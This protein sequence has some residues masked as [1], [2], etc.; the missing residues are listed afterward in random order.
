MGD[1][2]VFCGCGYGVCVCAVV[3]FLKG[4]NIEYSGW[5]RNVCVCVCLKIHVNTTSGD[6]I[7]A[8]RPVGF[9]GKILCG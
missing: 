7:I 9:L 5:G 6:R 2:G 3:S 8:S 4:I 1:D